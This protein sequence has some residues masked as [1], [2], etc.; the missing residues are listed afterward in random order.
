MKSKFLKNI[1]YLN[2][3]KLTMREFGNKYKLVRLKKKLLL[4]L[5]SK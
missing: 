3:G 5:L 2:H 4:L 1:M